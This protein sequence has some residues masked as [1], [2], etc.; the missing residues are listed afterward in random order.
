MPPSLRMMMTGIFVQDQL[1]M[2]GLPFDVVM[3]LVPN[4]AELVYHR[5]INIYE[6]MG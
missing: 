5:K 2:L 4:P 1:H 6:N 3:A